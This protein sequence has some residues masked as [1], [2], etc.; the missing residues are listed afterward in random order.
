MKRSSHTFPVT[1]ARVGC[2]K[3]YFLETITGTEV[4]IIFFFQ[5]LL[6]ACT[7]EGGMLKQDE[8]DGRAEW[9][10]ETGWRNASL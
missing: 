2:R 6:R 7:Y 1:S 3:Y 10:R 9:A 4:V 5:S 8:Q